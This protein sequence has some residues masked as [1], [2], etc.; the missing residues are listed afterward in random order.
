VATILF[1]SWLRMAKPDTTTGYEL[2]SIAAC[3]VGG[4]S[5]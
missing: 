5:L 2:D 1:L 3:V 4:V